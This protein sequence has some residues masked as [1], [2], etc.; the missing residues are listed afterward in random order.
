M[1][2]FVLAAMVGLAVAVTFW[3]TAMTMAQ[4]RCTVDWNPFDCDD[5]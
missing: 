5:R 1:R 2:D 4:P 3:A